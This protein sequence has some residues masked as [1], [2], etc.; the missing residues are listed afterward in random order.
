MGDGSHPANW[1]GAAVPCWPL[2]VYT[3]GYIEER[4]LGFDNIFVFFDNILLIFNNIM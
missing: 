1:G 2:L 4:K 3:V